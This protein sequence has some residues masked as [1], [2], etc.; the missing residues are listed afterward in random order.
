VNINGPIALL[1]LDFVPHLV[2]LLLQM[3]FPIST[4]IPEFDKFAFGFIFPF[5]YLGS[6]R[7]GPRTVYSSILNF[8]LFGG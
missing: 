3:L 5:L 8:S 2:P 6:L 7:G 1:S 4:E